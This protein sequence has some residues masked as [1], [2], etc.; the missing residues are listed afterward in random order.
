MAELESITV[1]TR[2]PE[3]WRFLDLETGEVW[4]YEDGFVADHDFSRQAQIWIEGEEAGRWN[5]EHQHMIDADL[6][7]P[8]TNPYLA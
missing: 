3:K 1:R 8:I 5:S 2:K 7:K 4:R 6:R